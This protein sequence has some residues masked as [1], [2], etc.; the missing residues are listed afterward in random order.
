M[1]LIN[2]VLVASWFWFIPLWFSIYL[3]WGLTPRSTG[4]DFAWFSIV[5]L[6]RQSVRALKGYSCASAVASFSIESKHNRWVL[7]SSSWTSV[8]TYNQPPST[9][10]VW[11]IAPFAKFIIAENVFN[12]SAH[13]VSCS[14]PN[15]DRNAIFSYQYEFGRITHFIILIL[16]RVSSELS[17]YEKEYGINQY[18]NA[19]LVFSS[20]LAVNLSSPSIF[21]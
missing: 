15:G 9:N 16:D 11:S 3:K 4:H 7:V 6:F 5:L 13:N 19:L 20:S 14:F 1:T 18:L 8:T 2:R 12:I 10:H 21:M 17:C